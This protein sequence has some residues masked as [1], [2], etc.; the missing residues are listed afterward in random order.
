MEQ[1]GKMETV[2]ITGGYGHNLNQNES[3]TQ[4]SGRFL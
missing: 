4:H 1:C 3:I 2:A